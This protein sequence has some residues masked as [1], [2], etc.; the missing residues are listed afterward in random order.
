[1]HRGTGR[2]R[3][4]RPPRAGGDAGSASDQLGGVAGD[5]SEAPSDGAGGTRRWTGAGDAAGHGRRARRRSGGHR[6]SGPVAA[7]PARRGR[8]TPAG[9]V[10]AVD[11][12]AVGRAAV[13]LGAG[14]GR[15]GDPVDHA[16]GIRLMV[17]PGD[18]VAD[19]A[20]L[21]ELHHNGPAGLADARTWPP[22]RSRSDRRRRR[23]PGARVGPPRRRDGALM[24]LSAHDA[25]PGA[26]LGRRSRIGWLRPRPSCAVAA[27]TAPTW[28]WSWAPGWARSPTASR[29]ATGA[30]R[31]DSALA[32]LGG[33]WPRRPAG[34][35]PARQPPGDRAVGP[36]APLRGPRS[37]TSPSGCASSAPWVCRA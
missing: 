34:Q 23:R 36:R 25:R 1:M 17:G 3:A 18:Q 20:P 32:A 5:A 26:S 24:T 14:R 10:A 9:A 4:R 6:R 29:D 31:R 19:G 27:W 12:E 37:A 8:R 22:R 28:R 11:A 13:L 7:G 2:R 33:R 30:V 35:R 21:L 15:V 16:A